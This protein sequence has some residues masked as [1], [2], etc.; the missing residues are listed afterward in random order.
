MSFARFSEG[1]LYVYLNT[2][3]LFECCGCGLQDGGCFFCRTAAEMIAHVKKHRRAGHDVPDRCLYQLGRDAET[4]NALADELRSGAA[5]RARAATKH[6][7]WP[8][9]YSP[10]ELPPQNTAGPF[11]CFLLDVEP[12]RGLQADDLVPTVLAHSKDQPPD[13][14]DRERLPWGSG[15]YEDFVYAKAMR[16]WD[17]FL[18]L[19]RIDGCPSVKG[20]P[21]LGQPDEIEGCE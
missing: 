21:R 19:S 16:A 4:L 6:Q 1:D 7:A 3:G 18:A 12:R 11:R 5:R 9:R 10:K 20:P 2:E 15:S 8:E 13:E 17:A 14:A